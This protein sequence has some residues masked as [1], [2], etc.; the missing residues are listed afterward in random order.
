[1]RLSVSVP[2][3]RS[4]LNNFFKNNLQI[5]LKISNFERVAN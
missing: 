4:N 5:V 3:V 1:M 2:S